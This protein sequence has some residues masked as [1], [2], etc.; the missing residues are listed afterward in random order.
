[1]GL[2]A[3]PDEKSFV[4]EST[5]LIR[6]PLARVWDHITN[7]D[8]TIYQSPPIFKFLGIPQPLRAELTGAGI[9]ARRTAW[10]NNGKRFTQIVLEW[11]EFS[12][13]R[14]SFSAIRLRL[15]CTRRS[16]I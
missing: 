1:M 8:L 5:I 3:M 14:F 11:R 15:A 10:F 13:F 2:C 7:V 4:L 9:W 12:C 16:R 6:S